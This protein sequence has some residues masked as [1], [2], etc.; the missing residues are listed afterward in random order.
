[1]K[2]ILIM[3]LIC[4]AAGS[5]FAETTCRPLNRATQ[6]CTA[7]MTTA[8]FNTVV[9]EKV[10]SVQEQQYWCWAASLSMLFQA[11]GVTLKQDRIV[12]QALGSRENIPQSGYNLERL[13]N[14]SYVLANGS[15]FT[16]TGSVTN[17]ETR[18]FQVNNYDIIS[19]LDEGH[20][21]VYGALG[22]A[23]LLT[24]VDYLADL[25][26]NPLRIVGGTVRD[27]WPGQGRRKL[28]PQEMIPSFVATVSIETAPNPRA[29]G[30]SA[31]RCRSDCKDARDICIDA[32]DSTND[33]CERRCESRYYCINWLYGNNL[34]RCEACKAPCA[35]TQ[36]MSEQRCKEVYDE[37]MAGCQH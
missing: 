29:T 2:T 20:P 19:T 5:A 17:V 9:A 34:D 16:V 22:H 30:R 4:M 18:T 25:Q 23:M 32:A 26:G 15:A 8:E 36:E 7:G 14:R 13:L 35:E 27:P 31:W 12:I 1:M 37:C 24:A 11:H 21:V 10:N 28:R 33:A 3:V 6:I